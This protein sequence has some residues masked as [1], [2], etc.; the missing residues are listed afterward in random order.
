MMTLA[1]VCAAKPARSETVE[2]FY[3]RRQIQVLVGNPSGGGYDVYARFLAKHLSR[4]V[5][6]NPSIVVANMPGANGMIMANHLFNR[7]AQDGT[8]VGMSNRSD[9]TEPLFGNSQARY[10]ARRFQWIGKHEQ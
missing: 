7:A 9:P 8:V 10:D 1:L 3:R 5:P 4:F 2:D 6:G